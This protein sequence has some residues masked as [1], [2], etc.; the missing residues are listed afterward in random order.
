MKFGAVPLTYG[1]APRHAIFA[2][3]VGLATAVGVALDDV[4]VA[5]A[6]GGADVVEDGGELSVPPGVPG[7]PLPIV[8]PPWQ[9]TTVAAPTISVAISDSR[10]CEVNVK[11]APGKKKLG[12][13]L[14][15]TRGAGRAL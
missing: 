13:L 8:A 6:N 11:P 1:A 4:G 9:P 12:L 14:A 10:R 2:R 7:G 5:V 3:S 15:M